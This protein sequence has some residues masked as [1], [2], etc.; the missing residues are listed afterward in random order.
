MKKS[1]K[2]ALL[3]MLATAFVMLAGVLLYRYFIGSRIQDGGRMENPDAY[4]AGKE[5][6]EFRWQQTH[7]N[8]SRYDAFLSGERPSRADR[9]VSEPGWRRDKRKREGCVFD[10]DPM[11]TYL[12][13]MV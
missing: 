5:L 10:P 4:R 6:I 13:A 12:G 7:T 3:I 2:I 9:T 8:S 1:R 11:A